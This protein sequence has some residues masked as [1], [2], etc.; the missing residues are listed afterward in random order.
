VAK[1]ATS[2]P[3]HVLMVEDNPDH[4]ELVRT[5]LAKAPEHVWRF[6]RAEAL[7]EALQI[8][9]ARPVDLV[10]LDLNLPDSRGMDTVA[11]VRAEA[12]ETPV[13][14]A[15]VDDDE[16]LGIEAIQ[17]GVQDFIVKG[18]LGPEELSRTLVLA[19]ER[20]RSQVAT[21]H[22]AAIVDHSEDAIVSA[23]LEGTILTWNA[24][25]E[26]ICGYLSA[27]VIGRPFQMLFTAE[28]EEAIENV[29]RR[30]CAGERIAPF[31]TVA[32][33][34]DGTRVYVSLALAPLRETVGPTQRPLAGAKVT[35][36]VAVARDI[37]QRKRDEQALRHSEEQYRLLFDTNPQPMW[38]Y[39]GDTLRFLAVNDAAIG[40]YGYSREEFL[41]MTLRDIR[42]ADELAAYDEQVRRRRSQQD[43][44]AFSLLRAWRHRRRDGGI[45]EVEVSVSPIRFE[46]RDAWLALAIDVTEKKRLEAQLL[47][48]QKME[49]VGRLAGGI[50]HD[51]NNLLGV[52]TGYGDLARRQLAPG[53]PVAGRVDQMLKAAARAADLTKQLLAFS[54]KQVLQPRV[55]NLNA[56]T[57]DMERMLRRLI[58]EHIQLVTVYA[59]ALGH[60][61]AD[62][63]QVGQVIVNLA[64]NARD[65]MPDGGRLMVETANV[66]LEEEYTAGRPDVKPGRYVMLSVT[67][68]GVG[69]TPETLDRIFEPF[70]TTKAEGH[71]TGLG[72]ATAYG[73][74][75]QSGGHIWTYSEPGKGTTFR[76]YFPRVD[77]AAD[78]LEPRSESISTVGGAETILVVEDDEALRTIIAEV[79]AGAGYSVLTARN[80]REAVFVVDGHGDSIDLII[81]DMVMPAMGGVAL[82]QRLDGQRFLFMSGYTEPS[83]AE[84]GGLT[85]GAAFL[86][87]PFTPGTLLRKVRE[88]LD[89]GQE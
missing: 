21:A 88:V 42:P 36:M 79:L 81:S 6:E 74:V 15:T 45:I 60:V 29:R 57:A 53:D 59:D 3:I 35:G 85:E 34:N 89:G 25:A 24:A 87:K 75:K 18:T 38:V 30:L 76:I 14:V 67:D 27:E 17:K 86:Q 39:D 84:E 73:I 52:I 55:V 19:I 20:K 10:L 2:D 56:V 32:L 4:A 58:G 48:A 13:V 61:R 71:G 49:S 66:D 7:K 12:P 51:F 50:A 54:R 83:V 43:R 63:G 64:I 41:S 23:T 80:G 47:Q 62:P 33:R 28:C 70:F 37:S 44:K 31:D 68:T 16:A 77:E 72:L 46:D 8:L 5:L 1:A 78:R 82:A 9:S 22:L 11:R 69:M 26:R 40:H 65:A